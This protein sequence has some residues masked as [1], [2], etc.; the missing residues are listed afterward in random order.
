QVEA[1]ELEAGTVK[2]RDIVRRRPD[3]AD[4]HFTL[5]YALRYGGFLEES[6][7]EGETALARDPGNAGFRSCHVTFQQSK[8][9]DKARQYALLDAGSNW[10]RNALADLLL[11]EGKLDESIAMRPA[12]VFGGI[13]L[14]TLLRSGPSPER[15]RAMKQVESQF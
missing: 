5:S 10:S 6:A 11:R 12:G 7:R 14:G 4:A 2:A 13:E 8:R 15:D 1:S 9:Y 3:S